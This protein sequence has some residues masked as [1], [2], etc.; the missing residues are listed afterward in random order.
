[1]SE[2]Q[3]LC[4]QAVYICKSESFRRWIDRCE[5][6]LDR[7]TTVAMAAEFIKRECDVRSRKEFDSDPEK[8]Y[9]FTQLLSRYRRELAGW[10]LPEDEFSKMQSEAAA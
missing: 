10:N 9:A 8:S 7:T 5:G 3:P 6:L 1:M 4:I 2:P